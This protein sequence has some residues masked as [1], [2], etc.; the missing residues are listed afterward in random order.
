VSGTSRP[1]LASDPDH[2]VQ[3]E[4]DSCGGYFYH[5][6]AAE[7]CPYCGEDSIYSREDGYVTNCDSKI[8]GDQ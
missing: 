5:R 4:C 2:V 3:A 7:Y 6:L 1:N 8:R